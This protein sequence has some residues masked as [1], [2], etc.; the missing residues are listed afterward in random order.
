MP[1]IDK[2]PDPTESVRVTHRTV[3]EI[4]GL[5]VTRL[6]ITPFRVIADQSS[7][8]RDEAGE[9][10]TTTRVWEVRG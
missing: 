9:R 10:L 7:L 1:H 8:E 6:E 4:C 3:I 2:G 5:L